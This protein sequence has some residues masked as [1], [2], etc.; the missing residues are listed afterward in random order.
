M[1]RGQK[2]EGR[3]TGSSECECVIGEERRRVSRGIREGKEEKED[4]GRRNGYINCK[5]EEY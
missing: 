2:N 3:R 5:A 1:D 4:R